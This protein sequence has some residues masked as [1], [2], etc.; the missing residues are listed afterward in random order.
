MIRR[1]NRNNILPASPDL[2]EPGLQS[3]LYETFL[4]DNFKS[5]STTIDLAQSKKFT[6]K[7]LLGVIPSNLFTNLSENSE[8]DYQVKKLH[9]EIFFKLL[10][11]GT[12]KSNKLSTRLLESYYNSAQFQFFCGKQEDQ[13]RH[14]SIA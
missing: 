12:L 2:Q 7:E 13:S 4:N 1:I 9:G 14:S 5:K 3:L 8:V 10:L 6:V 11:Y